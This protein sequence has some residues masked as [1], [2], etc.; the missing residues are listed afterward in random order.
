MCRGVEASVACVLSFLQSEWLLTW[1]RLD[2]GSSVIILR[3]LLT[4]LYVYALILLGQNMLDPSRTWEFSLTELRLQV[5]ASAEWYAAVFAGI[6][7]ALYARFASQWSYLAGLYNQI[8]NAETH[9]GCSSDALADWQAGFIEDAEE[10]HLASK[11]L[12]AS[13]I[14]DWGKKAQVENRF[15]KHGPGGKA[16]FDKLMTRVERSCTDRAARP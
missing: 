4:A 15:V 2:N 3:S 7:T 1:C 10:L 11:P 13:V 8:K 14:R 6:Y 12:F 5:I 9:A 16:W